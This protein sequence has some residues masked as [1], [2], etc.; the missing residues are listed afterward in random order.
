MLALVD[1]GY[2]A[3]PRFGIFDENQNW[4]IEGV[5]VY[6][7]FEVYDEPHLVAKGIDPC[8]KK[9]VEELLEELEISLLRKKLLHLQILTDRSG[10]KRMS[11]STPIDIY[12]RSIRFDAP[13]FI[14]NA[15]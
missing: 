3:V 14:Y 15:F 12:R 9:A 10:L 6:P 5:G 4:I 2:I 8:I 7:D 11:N 1:G 13:F